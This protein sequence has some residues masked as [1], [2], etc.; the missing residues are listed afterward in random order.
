[1]C[2]EVDNP[3]IKVTVQQGKQGGAMEQ[4]VAM[5]IYAVCKRLCLGEVAPL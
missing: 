4:G 1:M 2:K 5:N 3:V